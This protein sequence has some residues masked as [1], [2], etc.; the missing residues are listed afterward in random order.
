MKL[1][2]LTFLVAVIMSLGAMAQNMVKLNIHHKLDNTDFALE[3]G[4]KNNIDNDFKYYRL[5]YYV[6]EISIMHD[7]GQETMVEDL[8]ILV[9]ASE[10]T[11]VDLGAYGIDMV[12]G[13]KFHIGVD[14]AHNHLDPASYAAGHPLA[15]QNPSMH[16]GWAA[17]YRFIALEGQG[18]SSFNQLFELHG[19]GDNQYF[20]VDVPA[21]ASASNGTVSINIDA[22]YTR[23]LENI[24]V[25]SGVI[26]HG[27]VGDAIV[28]LENFRDHVFTA[29]A[30]TT[31]TNEANGLNQFSVFPNPVENGLAF[32]ALDIQE[33]IAVDI[34]VSNIL[35]K[36]IFETKNISG[37]QNLEWSV[38]GSGVYFVQVMQA[39]KVIATQK[40][41]AR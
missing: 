28:A 6:S 30:L 29:S 24:A 38:P 23:A 14:E 2:I 22:D 11:S 20:Q 25:N 17:G 27:E 37:Q 3:A 10:A 4:A 15:P 34:S 31:N 35:G 5:E 33:D 36:Q 12:E 13:I 19:L 18:G 41:I 1:R 7:G 39:G 9:D 40:L 32:I 16:W 8:W 21:T 26:A